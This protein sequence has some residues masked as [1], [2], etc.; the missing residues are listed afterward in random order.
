MPM[1]K[2]NFNDTFIDFTLLENCS[3]WGNARFITC[4]YQRIFLLVVVA[5]LLTLTSLGC[6]NEENVELKENKQ[7][8]IAQLQTTFSGQV[9]DEAENPVVGVF[10]SIRRFSYS[11][12][13]S[14]MTP[15]VLTEQTDAEGRF[16]FNHIHQGS[17]ALG[18]SVEPE[19]ETHT[20]RKDMTKI[21]SMDIEGMRLYPTSNDEFRRKIGFAI[22]AGDNIIDAVITVRP[23]IRIKKLIRAHVVFAD[24]SPLINANLYSFLKRRDF[25]GDAESASVYE[26]QTDS[27]GDFQYNLEANDEHFFYI[28]AVKY[29][30]L[31]A[32]AVPFM[33]KADEHEVDLVM[34]LNGNPNSLNK[35]STTEIRAYSWSGGSSNHEAHK[36]LDPPAVWIVN[37]QCG[38]C[39]P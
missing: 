32:K 16:T 4:L 3:Q 38:Q 33:F 5:V 21:L 22:Q 12:S 23:Q 1:K 36:L 39:N 8:D 37:S 18:V 10:V 26:I 14:Q 13:G 31:V 7:E 2:L 9:I 34:T 20:R 17:V 35:M 25:S 15:P 30:N 19:D 11:E 24:G 28:F 29:H 6:E 27:N